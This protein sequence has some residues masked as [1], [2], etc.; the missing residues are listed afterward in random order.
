[1]T[2]GTSKAM[3]VRPAVPG[4][5]LAIEARPLL[6]PQ[7]RPDRVKDDWGARRPPSQARTSGLARHAAN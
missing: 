7:T 3:T 5:A 6:K 1:M 2:R 4:D